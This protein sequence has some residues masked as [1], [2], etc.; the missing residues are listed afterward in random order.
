MNE[1]KKNLKKIIILGKG[2]GWEKCPDNTDSQIWGLNGLIYSPKKLDRVFIMDVL[3]EMPSVTSGTWELQDTVDQ[4]NRL[5]IPLVAPYEY[6]EIPLSEAFPIEEAIREFGVPYFNNTIAYMICYALLNGVEEIQIYGINQSSGSEYFYEKG[7]VE[8][9]LGIATGMGVRVSI[10]GKESELLANKERYGGSRLYGYNSTYENLVKVNEKFG[11]PKVKKLIAPKE[12][13]RVLY[14]G[15]EKSKGLRAV[16]ILGIKKLWN[17]FGTHP[18]GRWIISLNDAYNLGRFA[19]EN[20]PRRILDLGTG[21]GA[22][23]A[24]LRYALPDAEI[25]SIENSKKC[26]DIAEQLTPNVDIRHCEPEVFEVPGVA[27]REFSGYKN[28]PDGQWD[29]IVVDGPGPFE[30]DGEGMVDLPDGDL[31]RI[32]GRINE[33]GIVYIDGRKESVKLVKRYLSEFFQVI[34][35]TSQFAVLKRNNIMYKQELVADKLQEQLN[36]VKFFKNN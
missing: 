19:L 14:L 15:P 12:D 10:H 8:Y 4:I 11:I 6:E 33:N 30:Q 25:I 13:D 24:I 35:D 23:A 28:L 18:E 16:D 32:V 20:K 36:E 27:H 34:A 7:C 3:D 9:W 22:S 1:I 2:T 26:I 5:K 29:M 17:K 21:I 31:F